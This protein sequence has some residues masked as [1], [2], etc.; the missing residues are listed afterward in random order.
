M[1]GYLPRKRVPFPS[2]SMWSGQ[3]SSLTRR[4]RYVFESIWLLCRTSTMLNAEA[5]N[6]STTIFSSAQWKQRTVRGVWVESWELIFV[7]DQASDKLEPVLDIEL[8]CLRGGAMVRRIL[9]TLLTVMGNRWNDRASWVMSG[10]ESSVVKLCR[11]ARLSG[12]SWGLLC[13]IVM[14][15]GGETLLLLGDVGVE[16][17]LGGLLVILWLLPVKVPRW[18]GGPK[19]LLDDVEFCKRFDWFCWETLLGGVLLTGLA[20]R[21]VTD[22]DSRLT[23]PLKLGSEEERCKPVVVDVVRSSKDCKPA[24]I[25]DDDD[26]GCSDAPAGVKRRSRK[27]KFDQIRKSRTE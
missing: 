10:A 4:H 19:R 6:K 1:I 17:P 3:E 18:C 15:A 7:N 22:E 8:V 9:S 12:L 24:G 26:E 5:A 16:V 14:V 20:V 23:E 21:R 27:Y 2:F 13:G 11:F 25:N